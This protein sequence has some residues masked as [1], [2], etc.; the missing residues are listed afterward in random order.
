MVAVAGFLSV[1]VI[2]TVLVGIILPTGLLVDD[3]VAVAPFTLGILPSLYHG[4]QFHS[5][6]TCNNSWMPATDERDISNA[7]FAQNT[8]VPDPRSLS[9]LVAFW[10]QFIDHDIVLSESNASSPIYSLQMTPYDVLL[11]MTEN[12]VRVVD[13]QQCKESTTIASPEIDASTVYGD[14]LRPDTVSTLRDDNGRSC[15]LKTSTG[16]LLP[17]DPLQ[18]N[19]F[20]AG[21]PR[22][23]EHSILASLHTLWL[24]E[25][26]RLC[27]D[28]LQHKRPY[29]TQEQAF[30]KARQVVIA[31]I[32][33]ITYE[34]WLPALFGSQISLLQT[35]QEKRSDTRMSM[36]FSV[37]AYRMGHSLIPDPVGP[38]PLPGIFF[39]ASMLQEYGID[40]FLEA[41]YNTAAETVDA[42]VVDGLRNFLFA[43][44]P[45]QIGEDLVTRNL[46]RGREL[47][48]SSYY[49]MATCY[50][51]TPAGADADALVGLLSE[52]LVSGSSLPR[53]IAIILAEQFKRLRLYDARF[54]TKQQSAIGSVYYKEVLE[55]TLASVIRKNTNLT[56]SSDAI[57]YV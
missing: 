38:F 2:V 50:H 27:D 8:S 54:Y 13:A 28:I 18:S 12:N 24:R 42:L 51:T 32:Q 5:C 33:H 46:F 49:Q 37:V 16:N 44:G 40:A 10:G 47:G 31:K 14:Y 7:V 41:A 17:M 1:A 35:V 39:N 43:L 9:A 11:N 52:P 20:F 26:N 30:W 4:F 6:A 19:Q 22:A 21:D 36:D 45:L 57:F 15:K 29:W 3:P 53:T 56:P 55:T 48:M 34:E 23:T 25:H